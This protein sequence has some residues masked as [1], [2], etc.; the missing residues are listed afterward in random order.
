LTYALGRGLVADDMPTVR[1][2][3]R[4]AAAADYRFSAVLDGIV[5]SPPFRM[6]LKTAGED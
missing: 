5:T 2:I 6:R 1:A 3:T 4:R